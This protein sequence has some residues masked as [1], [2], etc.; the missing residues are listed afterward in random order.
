L[1]IN[2]LVDEEID[3][4]PPFPKVRAPEIR[5]R[6]GVIVTRTAPERIMEMF[7]MSGEIEAMC[8]RI[9][10]YRISPLERGKLIEM[11]DAS[12]ALVMRGDIDGYDKFNREFYEVICG[13]THNAGHFERN[14]PSRGG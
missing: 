7:E 4:N 14:R 13:A 10:T 2:S 6:R 5:P 8:V 11:H 12:E 1:T 9:A 3:G